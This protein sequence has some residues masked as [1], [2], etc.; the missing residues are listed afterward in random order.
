MRRKYFKMTLLFLISIFCF[1]KLL[2]VNE[3]FNSFNFE[4]LEEITN[5][6]MMMYFQ[7]C[8]FWF[9]PYLLFYID[10]FGSIDTTIDKLSPYFV[11]RYSSNKMFFNM[12]LNESL[13][14]S[15]LNL[16]VLYLSSIIIGFQNIS[17]LNIL[18]T[19]S[20]VYLVIIIYILIRILIKKY[21]FMNSFVL[22]VIMISIFYTAVSNNQLVS[23]FLL[24]SNSLWVLLINCMMV[25]VGMLTMGILSKRME[26]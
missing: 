10:L 25:I 4:V 8:L 20:R 15:I 2:G 1:R 24:L 17:A 9:L 11:L 26:Y 12:I 18:I 6:N 3:Y 7:L 5:N 14:K 21:R 23:Q 16:T 19:L 13:I 22:L